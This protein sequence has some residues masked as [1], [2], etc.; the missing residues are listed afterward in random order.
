M[1][2]SREEVEHVALLSRLALDESRIEQLTA[3]LGSI[4]D[5][6]EKLS[7]L[8]TQDVEPLSHPLPMS[9]VF[10]PDEPGESLKPEAALRN[11][12]GRR[13]GFFEVP[14]IIQ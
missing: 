6:I 14:R 2:I 5:Y 8:E 11:A 12:P 1:P 10:R 9:N 7:R 13:R 4:L 3:Q